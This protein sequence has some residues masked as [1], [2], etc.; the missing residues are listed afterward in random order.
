MNQKTLKKRI[1]VAAKKEPADTVVVNGKII[2]VFN[3]EIIEA[4]LAIVDGVIA[5]IGKYNGHN[6]IDAKGKYISPG[7]IDGHVHIESAMVTPAEFAKVVLPHGVTTVIA[8]PH[9]IANVSGVDG[10][11]FML[12]A[13]DDIPL[14]VYI[15]IP[16]CVP[17][18]PF[19]NAGAILEAID[20]KPFYN[21]DRCIALGEVM[22]YPAVHNRDD[23]MLEKL[24]QAMEN[25]RVIDGHAAGIEQ[26]GINV[27]MAAGITSDHECTTSEEA[28]DRLQRGMYVML[29]EG[30]ASRDLREL[31]KA[32]ND[33]NARRCLFVTDDKHLDDIIEEGSIDHNVRVAIEH[34]ISPITAIQMATLNGAERFKLTRKGAIAPGYDADFLLLDNLEE[35]MISETYVSGELVAKN[36]HCNQKIVSSVPDDRLMNSVNMKEIN[37][38]DLQINLPDDNVV[39]VISIIPNSIVTKHHI[40]KVPVQNKQFIPSIKDDL[41]KL[42]V[43]ERHHSRGTVGLGILNGLGLKTGAIAST[44]AH[45][46]HNIVA[47][48]MND[49]DLLKAVH[50]IREMQGGIAVVD[51]GEVLASIPLTISGLISNNHY[52][53]VYDGLQRVNDALSAIGFEGDFNPFI[54]LSFLALPVIPE[55]KLTDQGLFDVKQFKHISIER[56]EIYSNNN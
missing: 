44:I 34:G 31:L 22:D 3:Q 25:E 21:H 55:L 48:S 9:E 19:E 26:N 8:D 39:N 53:A 36:G 33:K 56:N 13:S 6:V 46:S 20:L 30:S 14:N 18:T 41:S 49:E 52:Q 2:D 38:E 27:Y 35:V 40:Q 12:D 54:T 17:A 7:F 1:A 10:I 47:A 5:G 4:D 45:D 37:K 29:R 16:S 42:V 50:V 23:A 24:L 51:K 43:L 15:G 11:Q 32:V 28:K